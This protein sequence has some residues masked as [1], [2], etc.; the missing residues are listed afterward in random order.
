MG[1]VLENRTPHIS[2][3]TGSY[4]YF[5]LSLLLERFLLRP[6]SHSHTCNDSSS[7]SGK[8]HELRR[9]GMGKNSGGGNNGN[10]ASHYLLAYI[11]ELFRTW[12]NGRG[13]QGLVSEES[14]HQPSGLNHHPQ[15][16]IGRPDINV[17]RG[18]RILLGEVE[19]MANLARS[20]RDF[21]SPRFREILIGTHET[22]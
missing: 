5:L 4:R 19:A 2:T 16:D 17:F 15:T 11:E 1:W 12:L 10:V 22:T 18:P 8:F 7:G 3:W 13:D 21:L 20:K 9:M 14:T 6:H